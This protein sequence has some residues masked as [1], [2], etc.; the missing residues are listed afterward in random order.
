MRYEEEKEK[1]L[2]EEAEAEADAQTADEEN[3][4]EIENYN[5]NMHVPNRREVEQYLVNRRRQEVGLRE[6]LL[7]F[8]T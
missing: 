3:V 4:R 2:L 6:R 5:A 1:E 8:C 7:Y